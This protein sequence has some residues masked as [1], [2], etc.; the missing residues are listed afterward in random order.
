MKTMFRP[1]LALLEPVEMQLNH[2]VQEAEHN[3]DPQKG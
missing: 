1:P 2:L 3:P